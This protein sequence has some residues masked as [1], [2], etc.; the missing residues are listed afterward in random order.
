MIPLQDIAFIDN[1]SL[2]ELTKFCNVD[3]MI[4]YV[5]DGVNPNDVFER[6]STSNSNKRI[7][8]QLFRFGVATAYYVR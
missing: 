7:S 2:E 4:V 6:L 1:N 8:Q 5:M 3:N